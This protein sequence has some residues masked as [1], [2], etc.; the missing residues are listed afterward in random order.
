MSALPV[1]PVFDGFGGRDLL[2]DTG[3]LVRKVEVL[4]W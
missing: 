2:L 1:K 3:G 4:S